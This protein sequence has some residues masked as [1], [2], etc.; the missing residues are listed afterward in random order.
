MSPL[1]LK[2]ASRQRGAALIVG[3]VM[4]VVLTLLAVS[5]MN[6][7]TLELLMAR[8]NQEQENAFQAAESA[9]DIAIARKNWTTAAP[10][11]V[12]PV[13]M[14][15][16]GTGQATTTCVDMTNVPGRGFSSGEGDNGIKAYHFDTI[17]QGSANN[18]AISFNNQSFYTIGP[19]SDGCT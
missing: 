1:Q 11:N 16:Y 19:G 10:T 4:M 15:G 17:A 3:L 6:T 14:G 18:N 12:L 5:S 13:S 2:P 7:A 9:I 8:N